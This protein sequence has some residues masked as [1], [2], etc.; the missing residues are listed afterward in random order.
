[1]QSACDFAKLSI[2]RVAELTPPVH[3]DGEKT[4]ADLKRRIAETIA[5]LEQ[6]KPEAME[7]AQRATSPSR[8]ARAS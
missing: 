1:M 2:G 3:D 6:A 5:V 7:A 8:P 4:F